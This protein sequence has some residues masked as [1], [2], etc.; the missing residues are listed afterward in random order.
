MKIVLL[1]LIQS[2][3]GPL[4]VSTFS[5]C[6]SE[7]V[8]IVITKTGQCPMGYVCMY[9]CIECTVLFGMCIRCVGPKHRIYV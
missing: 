8:V 7:I 1:L 9:V 2:W 3:S 5:M 6:S 4:S